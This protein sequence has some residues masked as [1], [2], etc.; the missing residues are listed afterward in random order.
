MSGPAPQNE[1]LALRVVGVVQG[2]G[3]RPFVHRLA[4]ELDLAGW[5]RNDPAGVSL[6]VEGTHDRLLDFLARL[7]SEKPRAAVLYAVDPRFLAPLGLRGFEIRPSATEGV[8]RAWLLPDLGVCEDCERELLDPADRRHRY[9]FLNCTNC[10][11]RYTILEDL[12]YDRPKTSMKS[13][14]MC[15]DCRREYGDPADRRFHAQPTACPVCGPRLLAVDPRNDSRSEGENALRAAVEWIAGG[16]IVALKGLGG[17]H[18]VVDATHEQALRR[19]RER[20]RRA[21]K[22]FAVMMRSV[23]EARRWVEVEPFLAA[24]MESAQA[25]IVLAPR[26]RRGWSEPAPSVAPGCPQLGVFLPY[27]PLHRVLLEDLGRPVVATSGNPSDQP[28]IHDDEEAM[29]AL[30]GICDAFLVHDR[31]I[32]RQA[33]D[34]VLQVLTRPTARPQLLRRARGFAPLPLLAPRELPPIVGLGGHMNVT[35]AVARGREVVLSP[36]LGEMST[37][38]G[39]AAYRRTLDDFLRLLDVRPEGLVRDDHPDYFTSALAEELAEAR[40]LAVERV[41]HH[42]AHLAA[43]ALEHELEGTLTA[44]A[45]DGTGAGD[46]GTVWGGEVLRGTAARS[47]RVGSLVPFSL[48]GGET[49]VHETWRTALSLLHGAYEGD[50]PE[51]FLPPVPVD[52]AVLRGVRALLGADRLLVRT[53]SMGRLFD[54]VSALLG[55]CFENTHQAQAPQMLEWASGPVGSDLGPPG[56]VEDAGPIRLDWRPCVRRLVEEKAAGVEVGSLARGFHDWLVDGALALLDAVG[57]GPTVLTGGVFCN[58]LL[59]ESLLVR[60]EQEGRDVRVHVQLP[61]TD[62]ALAAGQVWAAACRS[63]ERS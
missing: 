40:G 63:H 2:V 36:H 52:P 22:P 33:D 62:G 50:P 25:P 57:E 38:E 5:V 1:R 59:S 9:P 29:R 43:A 12:P 21:I 55:L 30:S 47:R 32:L 20:K 27:T 18:I 11:P 34:S 10:G 7:Q 56:L 49:A 51:E 16:R 15:E 19:L 6:E 45:W 37:A 4:A 60:A 39:R 48:A 26:T 61:P 24:Q 23:E 44:L 28:T 46:D 17:Y 54:G 3:F 41:Q 35:F 42:H 13:F 14:A 8:G 58:R 53:T 31:P